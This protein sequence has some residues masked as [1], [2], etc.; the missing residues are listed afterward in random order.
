MGAREKN[1]SKK[2][3]TATTAS[4]GKWSV[5]DASTG[6]F[7]DVRTGEPEAHDPPRSIANT[8]PRALRRPGRLSGRFVVGPEFFDPMSADDLRE[9]FGE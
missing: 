6:L 3:T 4:P 1:A 5:R 9:F 2:K 8:S 7:G